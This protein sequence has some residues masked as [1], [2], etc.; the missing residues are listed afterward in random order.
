MLEELHETHCGVTKMKEL[1]RGY[2]TWTNID[3]DIENK[4][5][6]CQRCCDTRYNPP[7]TAIH[8]WERPHTPWE[9]VHVDFAGPYLNQ[10]FLIVVDAY[11]K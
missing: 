11:S 1:A 9:R 8:P 4:V 2:C 5:Q 3:R 6:T 7:R 10:Y